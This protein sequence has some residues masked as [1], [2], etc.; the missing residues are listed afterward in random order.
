MSTKA[1][2]P[3]ETGF[4]FLAQLQHHRDTHLFGPTLGL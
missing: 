4:T 2:I 1:I 3:D